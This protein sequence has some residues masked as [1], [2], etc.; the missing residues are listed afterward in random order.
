LVSHDPSAL[1]QLIRGNSINVQKT[2]D[3]LGELLSNAELSN[4][5]ISHP[6][7]CALLEES[8]ELQA[9]TVCKPIIPAVSQIQ[10]EDLAR[11][12]PWNERE[13]ISPIQSQMILQCAYSLFFLDRNPASPFAFEPRDHPIVET[14]RLMKCG[15]DQKPGIHQLLELVEKI[16]TKFCPEILEYME[17]QEMETQ[18]I[19]M[20]TNQETPR[21]EMMLIVE[22]SVEN[23]LTFPKSDPSASKLER[24]Y[25]L[26]KRRFPFTEIDCTIVR[27]LL[28]TKHSRG[29]FLSYSMLI[30]DPLILLQCPLLVWKARGT[31]RVV[32]AII[33]RALQANE[34]LTRQTS[35]SED[36]AEEFIASR[37]MVV[38][39]CFLCLVSG[40]TMGPNGTDTSVL[41]PI[42]CD[43]L[44]GM[45]RLM[46]TKNPGLVAMLIKQG[47]PD[48]AVDWLVDNCAESIQDAHSLT[49]VLSDR[50]RL[51]ATERLRTADASI[52]IVIAH[53]TRDES[54]AKT[55]A[56]AA[57]NQLV[58]SFFLVLGPVGVPVNVLGEGERGMD[59]TQI[60]RKAM[61]RMLSAL[62]HVH[63]SR[64]GL[65]NECSM[66]LQKLATL[67]K[68]EG[69][70]SGTVANRRK[71]Q[72]KEIWDAVVK[73]LNAMGS[74]AQL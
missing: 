7:V 25:L 23:Y 57:L 21:R 3:I 55:L 32:L 4:E 40:C 14:L 34:H 52:R 19:F 16:V 33:K 22:Q 47:I 65:K 29:P 26:A 66:A 39:R 24:N 1:I 60:C 38:C 51:T 31:R 41:D 13:S 71:T 63:G 2:L 62:Q 30:R 35:Q 50:S 44:Y 49:I 17:D 70:Q 15:L 9:N 74:T 64:T 69:V 46:I 73:A 6:K 45:I 59:V 37:N 67:C 12:I 11:R 54:E 48:M 5:V 56:Y 18:S 42:R 61:F 28:T 53:G 8:I 36:A 20:P 27:A 58:A 72:L 10:I 68:S 43:V